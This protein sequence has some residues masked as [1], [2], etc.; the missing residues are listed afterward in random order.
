[1]EATI[2]GSSRKIYLQPDPALTN[3]DIA[4]ASKVQEE[5]KPA[6]E[7]RFTDNGTKVLAKLTQAHQGKPV[8]ILLNGKVVLAP[9]V[10]DPI[11]EGKAMITGNFT[12]EEAVRIAKGLSGQ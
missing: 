12:N 10:R 3:K 5:G 1:V 6:V 4:S 9:L 11:L 7:V 8:A 2:D